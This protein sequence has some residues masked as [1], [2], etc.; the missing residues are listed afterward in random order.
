MFAVVVSVE[1]IVGAGVGL[2]VDGGSGL[3]PVKIAQFPF[4]IV[5]ESKV[6]IKLN[7][8]SGGCVVHLFFNIYHRPLES[9]ENVVPTQFYKWKKIYTWKKEGKKRKVQN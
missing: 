4:G 5:S 8:N 7:C 6:I 9:S 2:C 3:P 1:G